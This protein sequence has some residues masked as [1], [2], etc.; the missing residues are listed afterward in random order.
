MEMHDY[1]NF[2]ALLQ[3]TFVGTTTWLS[4]QALTIPH[5]VKEVQESHVEL[6]L[7]RAHQLLFHADNVKLLED[8]RY[9]IKI[10]TEALIGT[11]K[12]ADL[13]VNMGR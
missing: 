8:N 5:T 3:N 13:E 12:E 2:S 1:H 10:N 4:L 9:T 7:N 6:K 11:S